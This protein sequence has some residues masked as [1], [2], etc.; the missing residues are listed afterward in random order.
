MNKNVSPPPLKDKLFQF[1]LVTV[2]I[3][4]A[5]ILWPFFGAIFWGVVVAILFGPLFRKLLRLMPCRRTLAA[6]ATLC[7]V[8][9]TAVLPLLLLMTAL[10]QQASTVVRKIQSGEIN[11]GRYFEQILS[12]LPSWLGEWLDRLGLGNLEAFK[13][14]MGSMV[15]QAT[16]F[17]ASQAIGIGQNTFDFLIAFCITLY[18]AFF[19][20]RD[21]AAL[22]HRMGQA[23]ALN[24]RDKHDL[25]SKFITVIRATVKGNILVA[26][27]QGALGGL[28]FW[29]LG[30]QGVLLWS[31]LMAVLSLLPALGAALVWF[32]VAAYF[33]V[34]GALWQGVS[35]M[36]YGVLVI[37][38]VDNM[39]RPM[40]VGKDT[41]MP[42]YMVLMSTLGGMAI[43][44]LNGFV[45]GPVI[46]AM[47]MAV[48]EIYLL[49]RK[50]QEP[51]LGGVM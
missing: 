47:F 38:L 30:V 21:G 14:K 42:D 12:V 22:A 48:W 32:P 49:R 46:A 26:L 23:V 3:A 4:F 1:L 43:F 29:F 33:L 34:T 20:L 15:T 45:I 10:L 39:L 2:S 6:L 5:W 24:P 31:V 19:L 9:L 7:V 8:L 37:G 36:V 11:F 28:A 41:K 27:T 25:F 35:L 17:L 13:Q 18:L 51:S 40:L 50:T 44:G 16:Q